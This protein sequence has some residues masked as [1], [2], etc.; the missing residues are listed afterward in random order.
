MP[1]TCADSPKGAERANK[2]FVNTT[3][4]QDGRNSEGF[5]LDCDPSIPE[6]SFALYLLTVVLEASPTVESYSIY[7]AEGVRTTNF[8]GTRFAKRV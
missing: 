5:W 2:V 4:S 8:D 1:L 6:Q 7:D 3:Y